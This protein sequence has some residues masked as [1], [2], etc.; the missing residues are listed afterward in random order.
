MGLLDPYIKDR[1]DKLFEKLAQNF[2]GFNNQLNDQEKDDIRIQ[3][4]RLQMEK[5]KEIRSA[6]VEIDERIDKEA[7]YKLQELEKEQARFRKELADCT[8]PEEQKRLLSEL[9]QIQKEIIYETENEKRN[10]DRILEL[11]RSKRRQYIQIKKMEVEQKQLEEVNAK[12]IE[13]NQK[14]FD[15]QMH[16]MDES[17]NAELE[18]QIRLLMNHEGPNKEQALILID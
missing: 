15:E 11:K 1:K 18:K 10:M 12:E 5:E 3:E 14:K 4:A 16:K 9:E 17:V 8:D 13:L 7:L 2:T 6:E